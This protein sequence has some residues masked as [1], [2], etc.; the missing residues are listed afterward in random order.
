MNKNRRNSHAEFAGS[1]LLGLL[2]A[3]EEFIRLL[4]RWFVI[5]LVLLA[6]F[7]IIGAVE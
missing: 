7:G 3:A 4:V 6:V 1:I 2:E 5:V